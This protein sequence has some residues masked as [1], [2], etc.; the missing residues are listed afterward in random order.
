MHTTV[1]S[2]EVALLIAISDDTFLSYRTGAYKLHYYETATNLKF[3]MLSDIKTANLRP[4]MHQIYVN[5]YVEFGS[6]HL[7]IGSVK[8]N[9][10]DSYQKPI[11]TS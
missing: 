6:P 4:V 11:I 3:V 7:S 1:C 2:V 5:L 9:E 10:R 8:T